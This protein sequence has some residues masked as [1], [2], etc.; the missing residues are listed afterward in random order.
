MDGNCEIMLNWEEVIYSCDEAS[1]NRW[2]HCC[3][4]DQ[5]T[6]YIFGGRNTDDLN[7]LLCFEID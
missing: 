6:I 5:L 7:D 3:C 1:L 4:V 2:G